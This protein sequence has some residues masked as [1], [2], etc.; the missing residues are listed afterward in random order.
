M[1]PPLSAEAETRTQARPGGAMDASVELAHKQALIDRLLE[2][3]G[4]KRHAGFVLTV[5]RRRLTSSASSTDPDRAAAE[6]YS[7]RGCAPLPAS[8]LVGGTRPRCSHAPT[9]PTRPLGV[10]ISRPCWI[11]NGS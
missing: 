6:R 3:H 7:N 2:A 4:N 5:Y 11:R 9:V 1:P 8:A 10:R